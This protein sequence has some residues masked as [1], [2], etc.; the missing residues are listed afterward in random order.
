MALEKGWSQEERAT[1]AALRMTERLTAKYPLL[2]LP[3]FVDI[4]KS[5]LNVPPL[6]WLHFKATVWLRKIWVFYFDV[7]W[8]IFCHAS[9]AATLESGFSLS[10]LNQAQWYR[11]IKLANP[12]SRISFSTEGALWSSRLQIQLSVL[13]VPFLFVGESCNFTLTNKFFPEKLS[14]PICCFPIRRLTQR[15]FP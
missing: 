13:V 2:L 8:N 10:V 11:H 6:V 12:H 4:V 7:R 14:P 1:T 3:L 15:S 5:I 9:T